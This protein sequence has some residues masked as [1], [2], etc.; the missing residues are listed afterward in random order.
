VR[1]LQE[2]VLA[3][4]ATKLA[5]LRVGGGERWTGTIESE[6]DGAGDK[7]W[8]MVRR[9]VVPPGVMLQQVYR[10]AVMQ[11]SLLG[12][13]HLLLPLV[14]PERRACTSA[15]ADHALVWR[16]AVVRFSDAGLRPQRRTRRRRR[17]RRTSG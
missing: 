4:W 13:L 14:E 11:P 2:V 7:Q 9:V 15:A 12:M 1:R 3:Q 6:E 10:C 5:S 17:G 8:R 16:C